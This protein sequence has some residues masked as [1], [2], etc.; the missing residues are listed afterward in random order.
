MTTPKTLKS[1]LDSGYIIKNIN[2]IHSKQCRVDVQPQFYS[3]GMK[4]VISY[5]LSSKY[6]KRFYSN[7]L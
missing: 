5:W 4:A 2:Y 1:A 7:V 6:V 3:A